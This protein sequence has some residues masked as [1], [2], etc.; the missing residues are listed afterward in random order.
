MFNIKNF[1]EEINKNGILQDNRYIVSFNPPEYLKSE[2]TDQLTLRCESAQIPG[3][4][5]ATVDG[6]PRIGYGPVETVPY[7]VIFD[8]VGLNFLL[9][10]KANVHQLFYKWMNSIVNYQSQ[11]HSSLKEARGPVSGMKPFEVGYKDKYST[12]IDIT[13]YN[14]SGEGNEAGT[15]VMAVKLY[16]AFPKSLPTFDVAWQSTNSPIKLPV[17]FAYTDY[18][19][20]Y[21]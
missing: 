11:G 4:S 2:K 7:G 6:P 14:H 15:K 20:K 8:D 13:V 5:F 3:V 19:I 16:R 18:T 10:A 12:D 21:Y 1:R 17:R 9:D